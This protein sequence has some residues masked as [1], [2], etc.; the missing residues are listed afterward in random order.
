MSRNGGAW[1]VPSSTSRTRPAC[2][3][4]NRRWPSPGAPVTCTGAPKL[5][6]VTSAGAA[7]AGAASASS[8]AAVSS[9]RTSV[10]GDAAVAGLERAALAGPCLEAAVERIGV[11]ARLP[12]GVGR[13]RRAPADATVEDDRTVAVDL[14]G[15]RGDLAELDVPRPGH[16]PRFPLVVL[17]D[18]DQ[19][20]VV[21]PRPQLLRRDVASRHG[22]GTV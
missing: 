6:T 3:T 16:P 19:L 13:H 2:S 9:A 14:R 5:P 17:A 18:V 12:E 7:C 21:A 8:T 10:G 11:V 1:T 20:D 15:V 4:T 22:P